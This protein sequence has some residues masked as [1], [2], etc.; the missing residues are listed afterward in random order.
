MFKELERG[1]FGYIKKSKIRHSLWI[2]MLLVIAVV[3]FITGLFIHKF[4]RANICTVLAV[5]MLLPAVKHMVAIIVMFPYK[6][7]SKERYDN[8]KNMINENTILMTD[9]VI[10][11][12]EKV[13]GLDFI[14]I[15]DNQLLGLTTYKNQD[16]NYIEEYLKKSLKDNGVDGVAVRIFTDEKQFTGCITDKQ[17]EQGELQ[18]RCYK[19]IRTLVV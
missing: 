13:M 19:H 8:I 7:I 9:M 14:L 2:L 17:F 6:S 16:R 15:T 10:T 18:D 4:D 11:S 5:L 3:M 12:P 1:S